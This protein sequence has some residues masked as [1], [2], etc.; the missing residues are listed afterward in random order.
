V[1]AGAVGCGTEEG[2][3]ALAHRQRVTVFIVN[4]LEG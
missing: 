2:E 3:F 4:S 1:R